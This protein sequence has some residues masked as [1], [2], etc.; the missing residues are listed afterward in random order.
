M[1][2][3]VKSSVLAFLAFVFLAPLSAPARA[4]AGHPI[5]VF[6]TTKGVIVVK[7]FPEDAP[8]TVANFIKLSNK[9]F[10]DG[11]R[12]HR[13]DDLG[14]P[15]GSGQGH[16][17][18]GGDPISKTRPPGST[19][20]GGGGPGYTIK[21]EFRANGVNNPLSHEQGAFAMARTS[22]GNNTA[23]SQFYFV[24]TPTRTLNDQYAVFGQ[25]IKGIDVANN[26][27]V[28]DTITSITIEHDRY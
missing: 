14:G 27:V 23:G 15:A 6:H 3:F 1:N 11:T 18:Q 17:V 5:A 22:Q 24:I 26:L 2:C 21:G 12:I 10:Y 16:I 4:A 20:I 25:V 13:V 28:G 7:L 8:I 19:D 9:H